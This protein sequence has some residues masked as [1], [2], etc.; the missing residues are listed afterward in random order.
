MNKVF[1]SVVVLGIGAYIVFGTVD[2][3]EEPKQEVKEVQEVNEVKG[4]NEVQEVKAATNSEEVYKIGEPIGIDGM[5]IVI[6]KAYYGQV[7]QYSHSNN[8]KILRLEGTVK[9]IN[10][11]YVYLDSTE[12]Q[13]YADDKRADMYFGNDGPNMFGGEVKTGKSIDFVLEYD[14]QE[15]DSYEIYYTPSFTFLDGLEIK[16]DISIDMM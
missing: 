4:I 2:Y 7:A 12:F 13:L 9:N 14:V 5:E 16:W 6:N 10:N 11:D 1:K 8:G 15:M 3:M